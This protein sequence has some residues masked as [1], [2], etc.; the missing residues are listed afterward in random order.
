MGDAVVSLI[1]GEPAKARRTLS[2]LN[3]HDGAEIAVLGL[4]TS[5]DAEAAIQAARTAQ[6]EWAAIPAVKRGEIL[7]KACALIEARAEELSTIVA[8]EAGKAMRDAR[9]ETSAAIQ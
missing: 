8:R 4:A 3:P 6:A 9:G 2:V 7:F 1:A 5:G